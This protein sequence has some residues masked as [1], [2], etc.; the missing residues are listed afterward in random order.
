MEPETITVGKYTVSKMG[1]LHGAR[2][3][4]NQRNVAALNLTDEAIADA[5]E[6]WALIA[7]CTDPFIPR[8]DYLKMLLV[9]S[10]PLVDA[11]E[12]L[13]A[14]IVAAPLSKKN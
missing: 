12:E 9:E 13:N 11:V 1:V 4:I 7:A 14:D 8:E 6:E 2:L 5:S 3:R 10:R